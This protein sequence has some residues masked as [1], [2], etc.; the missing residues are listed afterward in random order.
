MGETACPRNQIFVAHILVI[1]TNFVTTVNRT[2]QSEA[3]NSGR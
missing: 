1:F 2:D 3:L